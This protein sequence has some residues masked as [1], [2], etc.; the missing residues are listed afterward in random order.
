MSHYPE[1]FYQRTQRKESPIE[2]GDFLRGISAGQ[3]LPDI[4]FPYE[5]GLGPSVG[6]QKLRTP[7]T[8]EPSQVWLTL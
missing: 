7:R 6:I 1:V 3:I 4:S 8:E 5:F 2:V